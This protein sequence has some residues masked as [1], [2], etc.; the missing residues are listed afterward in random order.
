MNATAKRLRDHLRRQAAAYLVFLISLSPTLVAY[1]QVDKYIAERARSR[2]DAVA[3]AME[4]A[5]EQR[6]NRY[7][8]EL[9]AVQGLFRAS[10]TVNREEW[11]R[12]AQG[13]DM[14]RR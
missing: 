4:D 5:I 9:M 8:D 2:F 1:Y 10:I 3:L 11:R 7:L 6:V 13:A 14:A 12:Y